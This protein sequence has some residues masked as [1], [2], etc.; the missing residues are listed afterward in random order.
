MFVV[1]AGPM[2]A[3]T[4]LALATYGVRVHM[5]TRYGWLSNTPR[6][7]ITNQRSMEVFRD[8]GVS[9]AIARQ[10]SPWHLMGDTLFTTSFAGEEIARIRAW[11][12]GDERHGD[13]VA[14]SPEPMLDVPQ[15][16]LEA[17]LV[18]AAAERGARLSFDT[19]YLS[20]VQDAEGVTVRLRDRLTG[21]EYETRA[22][23]LVG[24]DG[25]RSQIV[26]ELGLPVEGE[27]G[28]AN[29]AYVQFTADLAR[30][31]R[32]RPSILYWVLSAGGAHG[33]IGMGLL[34]AVHPWH[35]WIAGWGFDPERG[36]PDLSAESVT[37]RIREFV[38]DPDLELTIESTST[39]QVNQAYAT[40]YSKGRVFC[41]GDAV[42]R[43]P[44][45]GGLGSNTSVQDAFNLAWK[46]AFVVKGHASPAL[47]D[48]YSQE[49]A[50]IGRQI[51]LRANKSRIEF[52]QFRAA[53]SLDDAEDRVGSALSTLVDPSLEGAAARDAL[54]DAL[55]VKDYEFNAQGVE[56]NQRYRSSAVAG[57]ASPPEVFARDRELY[58]Q[59]STR[60]GAKLP[61]A[62]LVD[63][64]GTR[65]STLDIVGRGMLT[66]VTGLSGTAWLE[67]LQR[68]DA[69]HLEAAVIGAPDARDLYRSWQRLREI[70]DAGALLVRPDGYIAWRCSS[71]IWD[72][73]DAAARLERALHATLGK[74]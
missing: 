26:E 66:L 49:R 3:T 5:V 19:E 48:S 31:V 68:I 30:Y 38:G 51:V 17:E 65:T 16:A 43:H 18:R 32:H 40:Q 23:Y 52:G 34:R 28:R 29:T 57:D 71:P 10:S 62:W 69:P 39:W 74:V 47:L 15:P 20:H 11:G 70:H 63:R 12:T 22:R 50:P 2:G 6:A 55:H 64:S 35:R 60:P 33:E 56:M 73:A 13:Y 9:E 42:H 46:L 21:R 45:S 7:H 61:H 72:A 59:P 36:E 58:L 4:A 24:A 1:G 44:P 14:G 27:M 41:G 54:G 37:S 8:L 53:L 67:A 25:A